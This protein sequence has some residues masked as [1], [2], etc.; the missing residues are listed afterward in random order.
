LKVG[1]ATSKK[2]SRISSSKK[3][4]QLEEK[5]Y[6]LT[7]EAVIFTIMG[8]LVAIILLW[9]F[10]LPAPNLS[11]AVYGG[12]I[13]PIYNANK[14]SIIGLIPTFPAIITNTGNVQIHIVICEIR[15]DKNGEPFNITEAPIT[16]IAN[17]KP[18]ETL[19][20]NFTKTFDYS[21]PVTN[22]TMS[23]WLGVTYWT[24][25]LGDRKT[26]WFNTVQDIT[27]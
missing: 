25:S 13:K 10:S 12:N 3:E 7:Q 1:R 2:K 27:K 18:Q 4:P 15:E 26:V 8:I 21:K 19:K 23:Y 6:N 17:L 11:I 14:T 24:Q 20:Y 9:N 22:L 5:N 16:D